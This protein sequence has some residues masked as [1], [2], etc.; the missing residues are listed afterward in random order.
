[1]EHEDVTPG[2][3]AE[4]RVIAR[5]LCSSGQMMGAVLR[6]LLD[7]LESARTER[8]AL[9]RALSAPPANERRG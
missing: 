6:D 2:R 1:M 5:Q 4:L 9:L 3:V 7:A 8:D